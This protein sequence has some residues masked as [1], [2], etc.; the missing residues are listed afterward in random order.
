MRSRWWRIRQRSL[1]VRLTLWYLV[2]FGATML[3]LGVVL[4]VQVQRSMVAQADSALQVAASQALAT[5]D[6]ENG[7]PAFQTTSTT[8]NVEQRLIAAGYAVR[9]L[10]SDGSVTQRLGGD[11]AVIAVQP[12]VTGTATTHAGTTDWRV[13]TQPV[14]VN[15]RQIGWL[16]AA[17]SLAL[18]QQTL[19]NLRRQALFSVPL[20]VALAGAGGLV[21]AD[22]ALRPISRGLAHVPSC[23]LHGGARY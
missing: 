11:T 17:Q 10:A 18:L 16:Q 8:Q 1:R 22:R 20:A 3:L 9:L 19:L 5:V 6:E 14:L 15:G 21:I 2:L 4:Y 12:L 23:Q 13:V 7:H